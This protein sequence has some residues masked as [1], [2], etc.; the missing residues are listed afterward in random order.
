VHK[1]GIFILFNLRDR[2]SFSN[3]EKYMQNQYSKYWIKA[4]LEKYGFQMY[5]KN[6]IEYVEGII[7]EGRI[8]EVAI[9]TG[10]PF[11]ETFHKKG[12]SVSGIDISPLL[13]RHC[14][15]NYPEINCIIGSAEELPF[16]DQNFDITYCFHSTWYF[17]DI[18]KSINE[19]VR[20]T[21]NGGLV[22]FD[23]ININNKSIL[24]SYNK[25]KKRYKFRF[26][27]YPLLIIYNIFKIITGKETLVWNFDLHECHIKPEILFEK[28]DELGLN[29][30]IMARQNDD[31]LLVLEG[32]HSF[33]EFSRL[34]FIIRK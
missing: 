1:N 23:T 24:E 13:I 30:R 20:V 18:V 27:Y 10:Y 7:S 25:K 28:L 6:L 19:M 32:R 4:R 11:A 3:H 17:N 9:G 5:D 21:K 8:L 26:F 34:I 16:D 29:F 14:K 22:I 15:L 31:S 33:E 2:I 12:Y